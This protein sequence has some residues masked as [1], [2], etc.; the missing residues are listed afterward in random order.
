M[1]I[2]F[3]RV[4]DVRQLPKGH[5]HCV[6]TDSIR[7]E[8][9]DVYNLPKTVTKGQDIYVLYDETKVTKKPKTINTE[10]GDRTFQN[11]NI[12][13]LTYGVANQYTAALASIEI[14]NLYKEATERMKQQDDTPQVLTTEGV[15]VNG[16]EETLF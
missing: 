9:V 3:A 1:R 7:G 4:V 14:G 2:I 12:R 15:P 16:G 6:Q 13:A 11:V 8:R 5:V 10:K